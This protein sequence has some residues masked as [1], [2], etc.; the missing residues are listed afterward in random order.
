MGQGG[1]ACPKSRPKMLDQGD[2]KAALD[3]LDRAE[4]KKVKQRS[5]GKCEVV[6]QLWLADDIGGGIVLARC[7][8]RAKHV[9]HQLGGWGRRARGPSALAVHKQHVC[10]E[11]HLEITGHVLKLLTGGDVPRFDMPYERNG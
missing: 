9:H 1:V 4:S 3:A 11:C 7:P 8:G 2:K 10:S 5:G 6:E